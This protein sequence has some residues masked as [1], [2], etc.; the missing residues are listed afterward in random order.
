VVD[1][2]ESTINANARYFAS[3]D[4][5]PKQALSMGIASINDAKEILLLAA[6]DGKADAV[7]AMLEGPV[8]EDC[9][10]SLNRDHDNI[11][12]VIDKAA[13]AKLDKSY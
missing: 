1:L 12:I 10:A 4:E 13:A 6:G 9:P 2:T 11:T 5:V 7:K 3:A 8:S